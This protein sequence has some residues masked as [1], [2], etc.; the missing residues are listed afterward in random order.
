MTNAVKQLQASYNMAEDRILWKL[1]TDTHQFQAWITRRYM[2]LLIPALHGQHP[3]TKE[4]LLPE[5]THQL[6]AMQKQTAGEEF[7]KQAED[8]V[9]Y[10]EPENVEEPLGDDPVLLAKLTFRGLESDSPVISFEPEQGPG[11]NLSFQPQITSALVQIFSQA[12]AKSDWGLQ[13][14]AI[15]EVPEQVTLQ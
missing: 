7:Q 8:N 14:E 12:L 1:R 5:K 4:N 15:M 9:A 3:T 6:H 13:L 10:E 2:K 11:F